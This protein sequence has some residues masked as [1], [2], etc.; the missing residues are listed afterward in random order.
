MSTGKRSDPLMGFRFLVEIDGISVARF[1]EVSGIQVEIETE[2]YEE[3]GVNE[4][5]HHFPKRAK[6]QNIVLKRGITDGQELWNWHQEVVSGIFKRKNGSIILLDS[7]GEE[8][9]RWNFVHA[10]PVKWTGPDLKAEGS[11]VAFE[12]IELVHEGIKK[13]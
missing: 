1:N 3:G 4:F 8:K 2:T 7:R 9:W 12:S 10:F 13:G 6:Y 5:I 11:G